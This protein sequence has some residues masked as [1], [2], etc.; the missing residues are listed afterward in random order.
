MTLG[1]RP[2]IA[3]IPARG[4]SKGIPR[5]NLVLVHGRPLIDYT[6]RAALDSTKVDHVWLSSDDASVLSIGSSLGAR[7]LERP[8]EYATDEASS[9]DVVRHFLT[10]LPESLRITDPIIIYLQPTSPL[11]RADHIDEALSLLG[12]RQASTL[13]SVVELRKSPYK[14]FGLD[15][16]GRLQSLFDERLSNARRQDLP[17][18]YL[19]NGAIY[20]FS[21]EDFENRGGFPSNGSVPF[22][23]TEED[24]VDLDSPEDL[25]RIERILGERNA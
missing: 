14:A 16:R 23:M 3:L 12:E 17:P 15:R 21:A 8:P 25:L 4:G 18:T 10:A 22:I 9:I 7:P 1:T 6:L 2:V 20:I 11:R 5:K 24:S 19:P 13:V